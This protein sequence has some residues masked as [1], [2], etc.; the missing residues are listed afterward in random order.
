MSSVQNLSSALDPLSG[1][2]VEPF[3][4][5]GVSTRPGQTLLAERAADF[6]KAGP[7]D[8]TSLI[9]SICQLSVVPALV[10]MTRLTEAV[11]TAGIGLG[12]EREPSPGRHH[13]SE[14]IVAG[15]LREV[16]PDKADNFTIRYYP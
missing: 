3:A 1:T 13:K 10:A 9:A 6:L 4:T 14:R 11:T 2:R 15:L 8:A 7:A 16:A 5:A 12:F